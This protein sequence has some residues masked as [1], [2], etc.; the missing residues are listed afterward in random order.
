MPP[1]EPATVSR[2]RENRMHG[3]MGGGRRPTSVGHAARRQAPPAY[4]TH[5]LASQGERYMS[6][7]L[8]RIRRDLQQR[9]EST[10][11]AAQEHERVRAALEA[12][13]HAV[14]P[15]KKVARRAAGRATEE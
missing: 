11:A 8:E 10:L 12:L 3:S 4:P 14:A 5:P 1:G 15:L 13:E 6:D 2:M 7:V 9:L